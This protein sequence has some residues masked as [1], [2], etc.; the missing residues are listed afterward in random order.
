MAADRSALALARAGV[1][2]VQA[3]GKTDTARAARLGREPAQAPDPNQGAA[4]EQARVPKQAREPRQAR[5]P[6]AAYATPN[7]WRASLCL[8]TSVVPYLLLSGAIYLLL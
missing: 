8:A 1:D 2:S 5:E 6:L 3:G 7:G 4:L